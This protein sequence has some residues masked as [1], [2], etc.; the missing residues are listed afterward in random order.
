MALTRFATSGPLPSVSGAVEQPGNVCLACGDCPRY[1]GHSPGRRLAMQIILWL[2]LANIQATQG[3][4]VGVLPG[5]ADD[6]TRK[7]KLNRNRA[8]VAHRLSVG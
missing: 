2:F 6:L 8:W 7:P 5:A 3:A 1:A 4:P